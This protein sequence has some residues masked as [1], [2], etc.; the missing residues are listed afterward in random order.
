[1][2]LALNKL[3]KQSATW[4]KVSAYIESEIAAL[5]KANEATLCPDDTNIIR[6]RIRALR[7]Q[8]IDLS[9]PELDVPD[10]LAPYSS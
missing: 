2:A 6:G 3:E 10:E 9:P 1:M 5:A 8:L 4:Q 7:K